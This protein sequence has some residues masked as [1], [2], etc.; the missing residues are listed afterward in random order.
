MDPEPPLE[1]KDTIPKCGLFKCTV[2]LTLPLPQHQQGF[3]NPAIACCRQ[4]LLDSF[5]QAIE[6]M[7]VKKKPENR[8]PLRYSR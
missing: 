5:S 6:M 2:F 3:F 4:E 8:C 7:L 1:W